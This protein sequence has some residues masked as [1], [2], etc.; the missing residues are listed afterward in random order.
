MAA[1]GP[2]GLPSSQIPS[3]A[4]HQ[5]EPVA[6][7]RVRILKEWENQDVLVE[8]GSSAL[9]EWVGEDVLRVATA[10]GCVSADWEDE[11]VF[12]VGFRAEPIG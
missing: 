2:R 4:G 6:T 1:S 10:Q 9:M 8:D 11:D 5:V 7:A 12:R 3:S